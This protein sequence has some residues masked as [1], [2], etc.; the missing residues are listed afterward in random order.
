MHKNFDRQ[1]EIIYMTP[2]G[3]IIKAHDPRPGR[4]GWYHAGVMNDYRC[5]ADVPS[6]EHSGR[7]VG[8]GAK[9]V[10]VNGSTRS[11]RADA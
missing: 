3:R 11:R 10:G 7:T 2:D 9:E 5:A 8:V 4:A 1:I 6:R